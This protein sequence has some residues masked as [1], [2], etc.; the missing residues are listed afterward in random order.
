MVRRGFTIVELLI[1]IVVMGILLV[2]GVVNLRGSQ[3]NARDEQ[4]RANIEV[5]A[6]NLEQFYSDGNG[7]GSSIGRYPSTVMI[8]TGPIENYLVNL[9]TK[10]LLDPGAPTGTTTSLVAAS[11]SNQSIATMAPKPTSANPR[12]VYQPMQTNNT[13]CTSESQ[14]CRKFNLYYYKETTDEIIM[15][16][17]RNQ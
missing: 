3:A 16:T 17:S 12:Y 5:I 1:V 7:T 6:A 15:V 8:S 11:N 2:L 10:V 14:P 13:R 4:R 9:D